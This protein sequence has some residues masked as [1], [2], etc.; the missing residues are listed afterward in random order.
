MIFGQYSP[1]Q[2]Q[3]FVFKSHIKCIWTTLAA[4][5]DCLPWTTAWD[6]IGRRLQ[7]NRSLGNQSKETMSP[8]W[9]LRSIPRDLVASEQPSDFNLDAGSSVKGEYKCGICLQRFPA[10]WG[11]DAFP[12]W[13]WYT[14]DEQEPVGKKV[15]WCGVNFF[16]YSANAGGLWP[17]GYSQVC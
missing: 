16:K 13:C 10:D 15:Y 11:F 17:T 3:F 14:H 1:S 9:C 8:V 12:I 7:G 2:C 4:L 6:E 5:P